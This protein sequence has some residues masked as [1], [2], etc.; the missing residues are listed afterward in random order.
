MIRPSPDRPPGNP[1]RQRLDCRRSKRAENGDC[2]RR[3]RFADPIRQRYYARHRQQ[4][5][6]RRMLSN[7]PAS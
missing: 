4:R 5:F 7:L 3:R 2:S 1:D 6:A